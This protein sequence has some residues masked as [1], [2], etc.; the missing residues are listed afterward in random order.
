MIDWVLGM[1]GKRIVW[2][3]LKGYHSGVIRGPWKWHI[4]PAAYPKKMG[5]LD[6]WAR[7]R[8]LL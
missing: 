2:V 7:K 8:G 6:W 4:A 5:N 1:F 3:G